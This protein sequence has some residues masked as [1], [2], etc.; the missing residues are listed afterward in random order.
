M[1]IHLSKGLDSEDWPLPR[2]LELIKLSL[3]VINFV[4]PEVKTDNSLSYWYTHLHHN[5]L[6]Y[7]TV[8][9]YVTDILKMYI[10][11]VYSK[12]NGVIITLYFF[13]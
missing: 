13:K 1:E 5:F 7:V 10:G 4:V 8:V 3:A 2:K 11:S 12:T 9:C 6:N